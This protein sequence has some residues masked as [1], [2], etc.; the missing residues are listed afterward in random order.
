MLRS[1]ITPHLINRAQFSQRE[2]SS[3]KLHSPKTTF[4]GVNVQ[5]S[6]RHYKGVADAIAKYG[7]SQK[8]YSILIRIVHVWMGD[9]GIEI[10]DRVFKGIKDGTVSPKAAKEEFLAL[11]KQKIAQQEAS[12]KEG[13]ELTPIHSF[14]KFTPKTPPAPDPTMT[15]LLDELTELEECCKFE[16]A[17]LEERCKSEAER[18]ILRKNNKEQAN[19]SSLPDIT[20]KARPVTEPTI[21][22]RL[23]QSPTI[24]RLLGS[25][26]TTV[27]S[28]PECIVPA[29]SIPL[30]LFPLST[31]S[32][33]LYKQT[34]SVDGIE[35][36][37]TMHFT[38][39]KMPH[40]K[41]VITVRPA[42]LN[43]TDKRFSQSVYKKTTHQVI[44][45]VIDVK[46][47]AQ[48]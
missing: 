47:I 18:E 29:P 32:Q 45:Q 2:P 35:K 30:Q 41:A 14:P 9:T 19:A 40:K 39:T 36:E 48:V 46:D 15:Q 17:D 25:E 27:R 20:P 21:V 38:V 11:S 1:K 4:A 10:V 22:K 33:F 31:R 44:H 8:N 13:R 37:S 23:V 42:D 6:E 24:V 12:R 34:M 43:G 26:P 3:F 16:L 28:L 5:L 7:F